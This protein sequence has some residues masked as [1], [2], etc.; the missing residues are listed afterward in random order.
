MSHPFLFHRENAKKE[1]AS[2]KSASNRIAPEI[3]HLLENTALQ[4]DVHD[5]ES[6]TVSATQLDFNKKV[7]N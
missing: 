7:N 2:I 6:H 5:F 1:A 4:T 3:E